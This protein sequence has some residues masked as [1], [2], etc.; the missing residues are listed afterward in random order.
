MNP[1]E[2]RRHKAQL[3]YENYKVEISERLKF[4]VEFAQGVLRGLTLANGGALIALF[5]FIG[6]TGTRHNGASLWWAFGSFGAGLVLT[7]LSSME[8]FF[9]QRFYMKSTIAQLWNEQ[10]NM[11]GGNGAHDFGTEYRRG[12]WAEIFG[13]TCAFL[14]LLAFIVGAGLALAGVVS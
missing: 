1:E 14:A 2:T 7:L 3:D 12:E 6:N 4:Q 11:L 9:S 5:T 8:A 10:E 13:I